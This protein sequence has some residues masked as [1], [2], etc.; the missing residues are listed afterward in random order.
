MWGCT[1]GRGNHMP[2]SLP[3]TRKVSLSSKKRK[4]GNVACAAAT[5][6]GEDGA[7]GRTD[8]TSPSGE[9]VWKQGTH[10]SHSVS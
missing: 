7:G 5:G 8:P 1:L 3:E 9:H 2:N 10:R 4:Q 6:S